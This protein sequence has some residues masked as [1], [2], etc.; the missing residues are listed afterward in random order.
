MIRN[1]SVVFAARRLGAA[2]LLVSGLGLATGPAVADPPTFRI[3]FKDG[4]VTPTKLQVPASTRII[5]TLVNSGKSPAE[6]ES[7]E[8][9]KEKV[10]AP[11]VTM[12]MAINTLDPGKYDFFDDF[13]PGTPSAVLIAK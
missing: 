1:R 13:H 7:V 3:E 11:G 6:F 2:C 4:V 10:L 8:L 9:H 5:L 12:A